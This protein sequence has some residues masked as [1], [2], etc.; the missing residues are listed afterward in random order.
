MGI[1]E[2]FKEHPVPF[3]SGLIIS[4]FATGIGVATSFPQVLG[5]SDR[6][7]ATEE[8]IFYV[9]TVS[10]KKLTERKSRDVDAEW[11]KQCRA[12]AIEKLI[13]LGFT[14]ANSESSRGTRAIRDSSSIAIVCQSNHNSIAI[15]GAAPASKYPE[16][17]AH[18]INLR[19]KL[20]EAWPEFVIN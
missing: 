14:V 18:A 4:A 16:L 9:G 1:V 10:S 20:A 5:I 11:E 19:A 12:L 8:L 7:P 2:K 17:E 3:I 15:V 13:K 6:A